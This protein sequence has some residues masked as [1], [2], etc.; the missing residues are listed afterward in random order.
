M[1]E[2]LVIANRPKWNFRNM[3]FC[4]LQVPLTG[5]QGGVYPQC[6]F[7]IRTPFQQVPGK[8]LKMTV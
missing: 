2:I 1:Q 8:S 3:C 7:L 6:S 4:F 5:L